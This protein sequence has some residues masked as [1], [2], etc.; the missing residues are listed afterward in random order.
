MKTETLYRLSG[1]AVVIGAVAMAVTTALELLV[2]PYNPYGSEL[3]LN[4]PVHVAKYVAGI[5]LLLG[6]PGVYL[7][8]R[9][10]AGRIG[11]LGFLAF[12]FGLALAGMPYNVVEFSM[13]PSLSQREAA[14]FL[15]RTWET[16]VVVP[17]LGMIGFPLVLLGLILFGIA[18][19]RASLLP[20]WT[21]WLSL[22][23]ILVGIA[24]MFLGGIFPGLVPHP[25]AWLTLGLTGYGYAL[26]AGKAAV[27]SMG[28]SPAP[29]T[30]RA[31][32]APAV[33]R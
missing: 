7:R 21:A 27:P 1:V 23:S 22:A 26:A 10:R 4:A 25:P 33:D 13:D 32:V 2:S 24:S 8:Q 15:E 11:F 3:W 19:L 30:G 28:A 20:R 29:T 12:A 5:V 17:I 9:K 14:E 31:M 18:T 6:L 16:S